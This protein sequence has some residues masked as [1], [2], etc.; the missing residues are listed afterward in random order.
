MRE[1]A[2]TNVALRIAL[3]DFQF[4][5]LL[6]HRIQNMVPGPGV[7]GKT[8]IRQYFSVNRFVTIAG[9]GSEWPTGI[10]RLE[11]PS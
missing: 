10:C 8:G 4:P 9:P 6:V 1:L 5:R 11:Q 3:I 2:A 7:I